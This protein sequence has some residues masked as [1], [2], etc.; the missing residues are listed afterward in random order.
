[1][2]NFTKTFLIVSLCFLSIFTGAYIAYRTSPT[3]EDVTLK[4]IED[5]IKYDT[6]PD[7]TGVFVD[8]HS[9]IDSVDQEHMAKY[10]DSLFMANKK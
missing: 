7:T 9:A 6:V 2:K 1:M 3:H 8:A 5:D 4:G 10:W